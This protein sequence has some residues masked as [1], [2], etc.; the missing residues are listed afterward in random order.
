[1]AGELIEK[2][3]VVSWTDSEDVVVASSPGL[4][5]GLTDVG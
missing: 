5:H 1:M 3:S 2:T 4:T